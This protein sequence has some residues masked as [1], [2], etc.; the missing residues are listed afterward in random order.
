MKARPVLTLAVLIFGGFAVGYARRRRP[1]VNPVGARPPTPGRRAVPALR[2][3]NIAF[4]EL[5][6]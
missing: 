3:G 6:R 4:V 2:N 1:R 5:T